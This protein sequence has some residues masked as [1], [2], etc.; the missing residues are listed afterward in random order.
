MLSMWLG[1]WT[2]RYSG[3]RNGRCRT[4]P[5]R[6][7]SSRPQLEALEDRLPPA[8]FTV[9]NPNDSGAGSLRQAILGANAAAGSDTIQFKIAASGVQTIALTSALPEVTD[10]VVID[11]TTEGGFAGTPL[12]V[13]DGTNA[14]VGS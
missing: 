4:K 12:I 11:G 13:I 7:P 14:G 1:D 8:T 5:C 2:N 9:V 3:A 6:R 10:P